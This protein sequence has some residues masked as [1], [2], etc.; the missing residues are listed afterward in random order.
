MAR[1]RTDGYRGD[2]GP[3]RGEA[4]SSDEPRLRS[5][6]GRRVSAGEPA[7]PPDRWSGAWEWQADLPGEPQDPTDVTE[8]ETSE[9]EASEQEASEQEA[10]DQ[11]ASDQ[12]TAE[13]GLLAWDSVEQDVPELEP[14]GPVVRHRVP[15]EV[16]DPFV[17]PM[18][19]PGTLRGARVRVSPLALLGVVVA[20]CVVAGVVGVRVWLAQSSAQPVPV[21]ALGG[22][23]GAS[24]AED[25]PADGAAATITAPSVPGQPAPSAGAAHQVGSATATEQAPTAGQ[26]TQSGFAGAPGDP[27]SPGVGPAGQIVVHVVGAVKKPG[28][29]RLD[30]G[31]RIG[32]AVRRCG[33]LSAAADPA[34]VNLARAAADGEQVVVLAKGQARPPAAPGGTGGP[35]APGPGGAGGSGGSGG[36]GGGAG[37][38]DLNS[39]DVA[40]LD[41]LPGVGPVTAQKILDWRA[42]NGRFGSVDELAEV[43]GIGPKTLERLRPHVRV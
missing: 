19:L 15:R 17:R 13:L 38:V 42:Q 23:A 6:L 12:G 14:I 25:S 36:S 29:V 28:L 1:S 10:S 32:D 37:Q 34:S 5:L 24:P 9:Q 4:S 7:P 11:E 40:A 21:A 31:A 16:T 22:S 8:Q 27:G 39:A 2:N 41:T 3:W 18:Q 26:Q 35:A 43:A 30:A 33:G 20:L